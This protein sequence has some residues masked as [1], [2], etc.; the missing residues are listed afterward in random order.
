MMD[1]VGPM[2]QQKITRKQHGIDIL[3]LTQECIQL[4]L[5]SVDTGLWVCHCV[6]MR[7]CVH[8]VEGLCE[9]HGFPYCVYL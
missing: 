1:P 6:C 8:N 5:S 2:I 7:V 4:L 9:P 3:L